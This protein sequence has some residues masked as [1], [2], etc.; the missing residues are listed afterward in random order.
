MRPGLGNQSHFGNRKVQVMHGKEHI[1]HETNLVHSTP[2][3]QQQS[4]LLSNK[5]LASRKF[6]WLD[7]LLFDW[8]RRS[9]LSFLVGYCIAQHINQYTHDTK[10]P[11]SDQTI[12]EE[13]GCSRVMVCRERLRLARHGWIDWRRTSSGN[14]YSLIFDKV[15]VFL[16]MR[17]ASRK[18]RN[19]RWK[20]RTDVSPTI[21]RDVSPMIHKHL[22]DT[23]EER[24]A[25]EERKRRASIFSEMRVPS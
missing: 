14:V 18:A 21:H 15:A 9:R 11:L 3:R 8:R 6:D 1:M 10:F 24:L 23:S 4:R 25:N 7:A 22:E 2:E 20:A 16:D 19:S 13:I 12:G 5:N 17:D